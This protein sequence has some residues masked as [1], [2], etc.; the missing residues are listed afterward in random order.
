MVDDSRKPGEEGREKA[1]PP[2]PWERRSPEKRASD[3]RHRLAGGDDVEYTADESYQAG[4][5]ADDQQSLQSRI[6]G[7]GRDL[8]PE[9]KEE[10]TRLCLGCG[11]VTTFVQGQCSSCGYKLAGAGG[12][13]PPEMLAPRFSAAGGVGS[14]IR[15]A[16]IVVVV[17][18]VIVVV[19]VLILRAGGG[20][21]GETDE[22]QAAAPLDEARSATA[23][24]GDGQLN[25][26]T[27][28]STF[29]GELVGVLEGGNGAWTNADVNAYVYRYGISNEMV[30]GRSQTIRV[31]AYVGGDGAE[32]AVAAPRSKYSARRSRRSSTS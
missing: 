2:A 15:I 19:G 23:P 25:A 32:T 26:V 9:S 3:L 4:Y 20:D 11:K 24:A 31:S 12:T 27:I 28:N 16:V 10:V 6:G 8:G 29:H 17:L 21:G 13:A 30:P 22:Q 14:V 1:G 7:G 18:A 5:L